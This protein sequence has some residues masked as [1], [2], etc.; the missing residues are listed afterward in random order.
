MGLR[1][2]AVIAFVVPAV[3]CS[4]PPASSAADSA[5]ADVRAVVTALQAAIKDKDAD[6]LWA[7]LDSKSQTEADQAAVAVQGKYKLAGAAGK[8][9]LEKEY[10]LPG[11]DLEKLDGPG[12]LRTAPF[13]K[14]YHELSDADITQVTVVGK[15]ATVYYTEKDGDKEKFDLAQRDGKWKAQLTIPK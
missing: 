13:W 12:Y 2:L 14:K 4:K 1:W 15:K 9:A 11:K 7:L 10:G 6:R 8:P 3:G 5:E